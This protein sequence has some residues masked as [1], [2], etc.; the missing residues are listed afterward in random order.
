MSRIKLY[1]HQNYVLDKTK[2]FENVAFY[3]DM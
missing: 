2:N 1:E 3:L